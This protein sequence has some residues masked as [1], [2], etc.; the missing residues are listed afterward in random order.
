MKITSQSFRDNAPLPAEFAFCKPDPDTHATMSSNLNP[1]LAWEDVPAG[2]RSLVL[3]CVDDDVPT[4][5][6]DVNQ[7]GRTIPADLPRC[8]FYHWVMVNIPPDCRDVAAGKCSSS[9][10]PRGKSSPPGPEGA[11]QGI[12]DYTGWFAGDEEM[13][14]DYFGYDGPC[15]PWNDSL[16]HHY[17]FRLY[18]LDV[19][20]LDVDDRF[21]GRDVT[22]TMEGHVLAQ[23]A[24]TGTY[25]LN[26]DVSAE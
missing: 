20:R 21:T 16:V 12:N 15:P 18:A 26:P 7:E 5:P 2:T 17:H 11:R 22:E 10:T 23:A 14:G 19:G 24:I 9:I 13:G 4:S 25:S 1:Q 3:L 6:D 8:D